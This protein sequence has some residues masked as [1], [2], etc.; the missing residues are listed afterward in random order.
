MAAY[1]GKEYRARVRRDGRV[2]FNGHYYTTHPQNLQ[3]SDP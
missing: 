3:R 1:K 2:R